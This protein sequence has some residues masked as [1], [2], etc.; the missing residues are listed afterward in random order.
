MRDWIND[1]MNMIEKIR[2]MMKQ[3]KLNIADISRG[4]DLPYSTIDN[5]FKREYKNVRI[6][7]L[8][9]LAKFFEVSI[10]YLVYEGEDF[11]K[12]REVS[13]DDRRL[14]ILWEKLSHDDK[15]KMLGRMEAKVEELEK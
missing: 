15:M 1:I 6:P 10:E 8:M 5:L 12:L 14:L 4:A 7:T 9:K 13:D 3:R 2:M 11:E